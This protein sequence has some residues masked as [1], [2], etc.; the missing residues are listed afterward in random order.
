MTAAATAA[1]VRRGETTAV[2]LVTRTLDQIQADPINAFTAVDDEALIRAASIDRMV[3]QGNDPGPLAGVPVALKDLIDHTGRITTAGS[4]FFRHQAT[5]TAPCVARLEAA[6]GI[7]VG[8]T[9]LHEFAF[10]FSS[11]NAHFGPVLNPWDPTTS[12]GGSSGGS[13]AAVAAG[14]VPLAIGT[15]TGGSVRVPAA[16]SG[17]VG[18]KVTHGAIPLTGVFP[19]APSLDTVGPLALDLNDLRIAF[20]L[21]RGT[22]IAD[23]WSRSGHGPGTEVH[24]AGV[25][26]AWL[27]ASP[28]AGDVEAAFEAALRALESQGVEVVEIDEP[29]IAPTSMIDA[30]AYG[31]VAPIHRT[32]WQDHPEAYGTEVA[33]RMLAVYS[34]T[35]DEHVAAHT[36]RARLQAAARRAFEQVDVILTPATCVTRKPLGVDT[37]PTRQGETGYRKALAWFTALVNNTACPAVVAPLAAD[38]GPPPA[39]QIIAPWWGEARALR[40]AERLTGRGILAPAKEAPSPNW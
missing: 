26:T 35:L 9:G 27:E 29:S 22:D 39:L 15:D 14:M 16:L 37:V 4:S 13:A 21:M 3:A 34:V 8:R 38:G 2:E 6:G 5:T 18:L 32:W 24:R 40:F 19:L 7:I 20:D 17:T 11:E 25:P 12:P 28:L 33:D 1:A 10:G 31:E 36:W 30:M 23:P